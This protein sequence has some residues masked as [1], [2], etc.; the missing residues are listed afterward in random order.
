MKLYYSPGACSLA[1]HIALR[2]AGLPFEP[3]QVDLAGKKTAT[4]ADYAEVNPKGYVPALE[5]DDG[6]VLTEAQIVLQWIADRK[7][8][9]GLAP[10]FGSLERYR[11]MEWLA[12]IATEIHKG[13]GPFWQP[14]TPEQ[15]RQSALAALSRRLD[16]VDGKLG[17]GPYL[18]GGNFTV[19]DAYLFTILGWTK[20]HRIDLS[21]WPR[22]AEYARRIAERPAVR[23]AMQAE[24][25]IR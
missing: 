4:G 20:I 22:L 6:Q 11:L 15:T 10:Q 5:L 18:M 19:A 13:F 16:Y 14:D 3:V 21:R 7:P 24:G 17:G 1:P 23:E 25:L 8:E 12:F 2:E 9:S